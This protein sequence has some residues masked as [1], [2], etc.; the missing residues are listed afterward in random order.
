MPDPVKKKPCPRCGKD[1][2]VGGVCEAED[3]GFDEGEAEKRA[4]GQAYVNR[5]ARAIEQEMEEADKK[6]KRG[7]KKSGSGFFG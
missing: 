1:M 6:A 7:G 3:C 5:R 2:I 4:F